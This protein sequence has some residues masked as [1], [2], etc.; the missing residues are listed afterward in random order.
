MENDN[1][2]DQWAHI[3]AQVKGYSDTDSSQVSAFFSRLEPQ[4]ISDSFFM[5]S[6]DNDFIKGWVEQHYLSII[7]RALRD[8]YGSEFTVAIAVDPTQEQRRTS[9]PRETVSPT[10]SYQP[11]S[12]IPSAPQ[13]Q[14]PSIKTEP[15]MPAYDETTMVD[16][17][18]TRTP[19]SS[20]IS[21]TTPEGSNQLVSSMKFSNFVI[22]DSN[23]MAYSMAVEVAESPGRTPLNP[24]FI[25]GKSGLGKTHL[26]C[27]I[28][29]YVEETRPELHVIYVDA[30]DFVDKHVEAAV[31]HDREKASFKNFKTGYEDADVLLIDDLQSLQGKKQTLDIVFQLFNSLTSR[32]KQIVL[33]ADRA[34]KNMI[35]DDRYKSR[36]SS[37]GIID[38]Q[39]PEIET[40]LGIVKSYVREYSRNAGLDNFSLDPEIQL[41]IAE[42]SSSNIRE[43]KGAVN[44]VIYQ[45]LYSDRPNITIEE[46]RRLLQNHFSGSTSNNLTVNDIQK[47]VEDYY[48]ISHNELVGK[49]R[50]KSIAYPR[51]MAIY[52]CRQLLDIPY[53]DIA[54]KFNRDHST[55]VY[56]C[57]VIED[58]IKDDINVQSEVETLCKNIRNL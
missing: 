48:R 25:Y 21:T 8:L 44:N 3:C 34:P 10:P 23:R 27:A 28:K 2:N 15:Y 33:S 20:G 29:N 11:T 52:L 55:A 57:G 39:P 36:F 41:F 30:D 9:A 5:L 17:Y 6:A 1:L 58:L 12:V 43:M 38:I 13:D 7:A 37:G 24:L 56:S 49:G 45:I 22:G 42:N 51:H 31:A 47:E 4:A 35:L 14:P 32:G 40:K 50:S 26:M 46:V 19:L 16:H 54:K 53:D 18:L